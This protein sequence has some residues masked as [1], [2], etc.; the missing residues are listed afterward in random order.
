MSNRQ[1]LRLTWVGKNKR[2]KLCRESFVR[3]DEIEAK[4]NTLIKQLKT[5]L[6][7]KVQVCSLFAVEWGLQ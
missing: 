6:E 2:P 4:R 3:Q 1:K 7:Q 5:Q